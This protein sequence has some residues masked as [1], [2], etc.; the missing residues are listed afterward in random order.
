MPD[1]NEINPT[2]EKLKL[3]KLMPTSLSSAELSQLSN[4]LKRRAFFSAKV[5][6][7]DVLQRL[8]D[9]TVRLADVKEVSIEGQPVSRAGIS[10][11]KA[12]LAAREYLDS[13]SYKA[14]GEG[15]QDLR[16]EGRLNLIYKTNLQQAQGMGYAAAGNEPAVLD[17]FPCVELKRVAYRKVPRGTEEGE[18]D[19]YWQERWVEAGGELVGEDGDRMVCK[20]DDSIRGEVSELDAYGPPGF[21]SGYDWVDV[22]RAEAVALGVIDEDEDSEAANL[23]MSEELPA[24]LDELL[25][26]AVADALTDKIISN[27]FASEGVGHEFHGNQWT[28]QMYH[29]TDKEFQE[30]DDA[31]MGSTTDEGWL[32]QG[33][34]FST[35]PKIGRTNK[36]TMQRTGELENPLRLKMTN[37]SGDKK[38]IVRKSLGL[39]PDATAK[40]VTDAAKEQ[41][42]DGVMLDYSSLGYNHNEIVVF[43]KTSI[44]ASQAANVISLE[45]A[46]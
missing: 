16:S 4:Q 14:E 37:W 31:K 34:Y 41:G 18:P 12:R 1:Q 35:D 38:A 40:Q 43:K 36:F 9:L 39:K 2:A 3:K 42:H 5:Y 7:A 46:A 29:G 19:G 6:Q 24:S 15:M 21:N 44:K 30:F 32:G 25:T 8:Q 20:K 28:G 10:L 27:I 17:A 13:I 11:P 22:D 23:S 45:V 33:H 26:S